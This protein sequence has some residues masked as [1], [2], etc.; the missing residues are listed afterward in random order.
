MNSIM[1]D[2][3][4]DKYMEQLGYEKQSNNLPK[5]LNI[6]GDE[7]IINC[8]YKKDNVDLYTGLDKN[9]G[10][11]VAYIYRPSCDQWQRI[12]Y[13]NDLKL[14]YG[15]ILYCSNHDMAYMYNRGIY[16]KF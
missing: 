6:Y 8:L 14:F 10:N 12:S 1:N 13:E 11:L 2:D 16:V 4:F 9:N 7:I 3:M 15:G 5:Y